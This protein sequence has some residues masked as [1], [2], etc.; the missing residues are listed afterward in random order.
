MLRG[1]GKLSWLAWPLLCVLDLHLVIDTILENVEEEDDAFNY[2]GRLF[3]SRDYVP[4]PISWLA[5]K[6][7]DREELIREVDQYFCA[8]RGN[9]E[10]VPL[11]EEKIRN[12]K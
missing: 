2:A 9:C 4:T 12:L 8:K 10:F 3:V 7:L 6:I 1:F 11:Y 5:L